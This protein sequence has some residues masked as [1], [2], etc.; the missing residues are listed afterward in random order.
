MV[1][2]LD[3][4]YYEMAFSLLLGSYATA[5]A[6][7]DK[8][9]AVSTD[10]KSVFRREPELCR[11]SYSSCHIHVTL[12]ERRVV[13]IGLSCQVEKRS[14]A[15]RGYDADIVA[16]MMSSLFMVKG[17]TLMYVLCFRCHRVAP[18]KCIY[19]F[20]GVVILQCDQGS[21]L[22]TQEIRFG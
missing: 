21:R 16:H 18:Q 12:S 5:N 3:A 8:C 10:L 20:D 1:A 2:T 6:R 13:L 11:H 19:H 9:F 17:F 22:K 7:Q 4:S 15:L 14:Y